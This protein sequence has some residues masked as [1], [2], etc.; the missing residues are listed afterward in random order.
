[1]MVGHRIQLERDGLNDD[2]GLVWDEIVELWTDHENHAAGLKEKC[3]Q[4]PLTDEQ[5]NC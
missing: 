3:Q 5:E 1:M 4:P 2:A